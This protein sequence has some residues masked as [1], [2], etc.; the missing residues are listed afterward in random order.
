MIFLGTRLAIAPQQRSDGGFPRSVAE[1]VIR[2]GFTPP[3]EE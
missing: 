3:D 2:R 1:N